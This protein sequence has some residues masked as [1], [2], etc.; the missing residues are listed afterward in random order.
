VLLLGPLPAVILAVVLSAFD[1]V[2]RAA[3]PASALLGPD[4]SHEDAVRR[5]THSGLPAMAALPGLV[6]YRFSGALFYANGDALRQDVEGIV[7]ATDGQLDWLVLDA[8]AVVDIDPT[9]A[10]A[11]H[12]AVDLLEAAGARFGVSRATEPTRALLDR[13][14]V[15]EREVLQFS[16][17]RE[18]VA[19]YQAWLA[20]PDDDGRVPGGDRPSSG[21]PGGRVD[22]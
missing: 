19:A 3:H 10:D 9:A 16:S 13:Y 18:A 22:G 17:N 4:L 5:Y 20:A 12:D 2:R 21:D 11:L 8:E 6:I 15:L 14:G 7:A 1:V